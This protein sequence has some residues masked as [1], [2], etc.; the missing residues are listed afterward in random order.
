MTLAEEFMAWVRVNYPPKDMPG[1]PPADWDRDNEMYI[2][3]G[4]RVGKPKSI[5]Q[6][7]PIKKCDIPEKFF[8]LGGGP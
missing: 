1:G 2:R 8:V 5:Q 7:G 6:H 3:V 4:N